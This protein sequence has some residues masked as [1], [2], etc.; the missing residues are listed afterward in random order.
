[1]KNFPGP[2]RSQRTFKYKEKTAFSYS[3]QSVVHCRKFSMKQN[4]LHYCCLFSIWTSRKMHD[5]QGYFSRTFQD[6]SD[7]LGLSRS[8]NF[9]E[10]N[11]GL[12]RKRGNPDYTI[13]HYTMQLLYLVLWELMVVWVYCSYCCETDFHRVNCACIVLYSICC[14]G[15]DFN[16]IFFSYKFR[17]AI[18]ASLI[19]YG[20]VE[21]NVPLDT[22]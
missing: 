5:F 11:P 16:T 12:S 10:K 15:C 22:V 17:H 18:S 13:L 6:Q 21:F 20:I 19:W 2:F 7:F 8:W 9:Q 3:I 1:M 4:V 14:F